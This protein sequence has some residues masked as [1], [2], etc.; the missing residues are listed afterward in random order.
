MPGDVAVL[1]VDDDPLLCETASPTLS[2]VEMDVEAA[3]FAAAAALDAA[4]RG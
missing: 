1:G 2:S 4:M 3:G